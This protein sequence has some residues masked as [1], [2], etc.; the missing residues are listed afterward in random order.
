M[1]RD[2][3]SLE[4]QVGHHWSMVITVTRLY[5]SMVIAAA[6]LYISMVISN[7]IDVFKINFHH[8]FTSVV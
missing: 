3:V 2:T 6:M 4:T 5:I 7:S 1:K 8:Q